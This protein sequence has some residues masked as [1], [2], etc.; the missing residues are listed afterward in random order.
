MVWYFTVKFLSFSLQSIFFRSEMLYIH[1]IEFFWE[2]MSRSATCG[3]QS[4]LRLRFIPRWHSSLEKN[5]RFIKLVFG[6]LSISISFEF[7]QLILYTFPST[8]NPQKM[9][10][11]KTFQLFVKVE[12]LQVICVQF[13]QNLPTA[14]RTL[15]S[16]IS[17]IYIWRLKM[18]CCLWEGSTAQSLAALPS[19]M[20]PMSSWTAPIDLISP[21]S[22]TLIPIANARFS[23]PLTFVTNSFAPYARNWGK[24]KT[25]RIY[26]RWPPAYLV[27]IT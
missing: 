3:F 18:L 22:F 13:L 1:E 2:T 26:W 8:S 17:E 15:E 12:I 14:N 7:W 21:M 16:Q 9:V 20:E 24:G 10:P 23:L 4:G 6:C 27:L 5:N 25:N 19:F 11:F